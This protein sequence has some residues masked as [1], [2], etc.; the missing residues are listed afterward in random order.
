MDKDLF[1]L[2]NK[3][4][5]VVRETDK[6]PAHDLSGVL[7]GLFGE[8]GSVMAT[9]KK[10]RREGDVY[11]EYAKACVEE[12]GDTLW[13][14]TAVC[15][16][17]GVNIADMFATVVRASRNEDNSTS[18]EG[19]VV[20]TAIPLMALGEAASRLLVFTHTTQSVN[21]DLAGFSEAYISALQAAG[22]R[23]KDVIGKNIEKVS[24]RFLAVD[25]KRLPSFDA[26]FPEDERLPEYFEIDIYQRKNGR[27]YLRW[28]GV[29]IGDPLTDNIA[30]SDGYRFH[31]VFHLA[32]AAI[33][34]WSP[35]FRAL[36]KHKRKSDPAVDEA[37]DGGRAIVVEEGLEA[38][39][40]SY[41]K[42][43]EFFAGK[44]SLPFDLLKT[45]EQFVN[46]YEVQACPLKLWEEA[47]LRGYSVFRDV[48]ENGGGT[49][50]GDR[51]A[52][53]VVYRHYR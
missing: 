5:R 35:T 49:V 41:A 26:G 30:E 15:N 14:L 4:D 32:N 9:A 10:L 46:G 40:F 52:R 2:L 27:S 8:V 39:I 44:N 7:M 3:F 13:Y 33:L 29:F 12:F 19:L 6:M 45:V 47:I 50:I 23:L 11:S 25:A 36:I 28:N 1:E 48:L 37:E 53:S 18:L 24:G 51:N 20:P 34:H 21:E 17:L 42:S 31:D 16:R 38:W 43:L 22:L